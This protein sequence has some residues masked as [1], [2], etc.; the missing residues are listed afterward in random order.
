MVGV[1]IMEQKDYKKIADI[2]KRSIDCRTDVVILRLADY[3]QKETEYKVSLNKKGEQINIPLF[4][5]EQFLK[6][7]GVE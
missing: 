1:V 6:D 7:A 2:L 5:R 3:F 4:N